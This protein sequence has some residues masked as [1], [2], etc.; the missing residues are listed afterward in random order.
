ML[1]TSWKPHN[2]KNKHQNWTFSLF[3]RFQASVT[4]VSSGVL[5]PRALSVFRWTE[6]RSDSD[7]RGGFDYCANS[8]VRQLDPHP[9]LPPSFHPFIPPSFILHNTMLS[10]CTCLHFICKDV[11]LVLIIDWNPVSDSFY[12]IVNL[13]THNLLFVENDWAAEWRVVVKRRCSPDCDAVKHQHLFLWKLK[14]HSLFLW[15]HPVELII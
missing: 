6:R 10:E 4:L 11:I 3:S 1:L 9:H 15:S 2:V 5:I 13:V 14:L 8:P 12:L 7:V